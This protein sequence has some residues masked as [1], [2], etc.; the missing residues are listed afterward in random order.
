MGILVQKQHPKLA[1]LPDLGNT[2][3]KNKSFKSQAY[4]RFYHGL[5]CVR[6]RSLSVGCSSWQQKKSQKLGT[7]CCVTALTADTMSYVMCLRDVQG[8]L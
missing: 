6:V 7:S 5:Q 8:A 1:L 2:R 4:L 3:C